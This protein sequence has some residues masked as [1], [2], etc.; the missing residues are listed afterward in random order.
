MSNPSSAKTQLRQHFRSHRQNLSTS[1]RLRAAE[2]IA[3]RLCSST[4][5]QQ[6][7]HI[8]VYASL[9]DEISLSEFISQARAD[10]KSLYL[11]VIAPQPD[12][13]TMEFMPWETQTELVTNRFGIPEPVC[14]GITQTDETPDTKPDALDLILVP[15]LAYDQSGN[16]LGMGAGYYDRYFSSRVKNNRHAHKLIKLGVAHSTQSAITLPSDDWDIKLDALVNEKTIIK[17]T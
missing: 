2:Q 6:A 5:Y 16:R 11:P 15:L 8:G 3:A 10:G 17:F 1:E 14:P 4:L 13:R 9:P 7:Q 12:S